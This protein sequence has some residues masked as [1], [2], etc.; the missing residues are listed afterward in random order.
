VKHKEKVIFDQIRMM[1]KHK[2]TVTDRYHGTIFSVIAN[3]PVI[4]LGSTDHKLSSGVKWFSD[5]LFSKVIYFAS[6]IDEAVKIAEKIYGTYDY[7]NKLPQY[8]NEKYWDKID[9]V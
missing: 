2:L 1:S 3:T 4:V 7:D 8:F 6:S 9:L 5:K